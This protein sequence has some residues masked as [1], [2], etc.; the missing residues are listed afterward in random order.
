MDKKG[1][2]EFALYFPP[3]HSDDDVHRRITEQTKEEPISW[4][5]P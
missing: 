3:V 5:D 4:R 1:Y 2:S